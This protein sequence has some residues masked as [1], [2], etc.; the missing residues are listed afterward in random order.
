MRQMFDSDNETYPDGVEIIAAYVDGARTGRNYER[1]RQK[2][3]GARIWRISAIGEADGDVIDIEPGCVWPPEN[4]IDWINRQRDQGRNPA[5]YC[6][7]STLAR[8]LRAFAAA[9]IATPPWWRADYNG[10]SA[11][12]MGEIAHQYANPPMTGSHWDSSVIADYLPAVDD[13]VAPRGGGVVLAAVQSA[14]ANTGFGPFDGVHFNLAT[15][16]C[17]GLLTGPAN[18]HGGFFVEERAAIA[19]VRGRLQELGYAPGEAGWAAGLFEQ[20]TADAAAAWQALNMPRVT[21]LPGQVWG[22]DWAKLFGPD[23]VPAGAR[24]KAPVPVAAAFSKPPWPGGFG[25]DDF[26]GDVNGPAN[27]HGGD[28]AADGAD[29]ISAIRYVQQQMIVRG[30]VP[31]ITDPAGGWADGRFERP[32]VEAV[33]AWQHAAFAAQTTRFGEVWPDDYGR[34]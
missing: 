29:V 20:P 33:A 2:H 23:N 9:G 12:E 28:P 19:T 13:G 25:P 3:P 11:L 14:P 17:Y 27:S 32:T 21:A 30:F 15:G 34:L 24:P 4:A 26:L 8:C 16:H 7:T 5:F 6:N 10:V 22:D 1:A 18:C 31:G